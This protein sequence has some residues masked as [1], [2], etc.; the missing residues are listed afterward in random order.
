MPP[1]P[2]PIQTSEPASASTARSVPS[3]SCIGFMPT[4]MNSGD[5]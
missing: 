5:A 2:V 3:A 1:E 4:T